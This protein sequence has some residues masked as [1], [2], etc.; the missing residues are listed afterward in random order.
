MTVF[1]KLDPDIITFHILPN[2]D[3]KT[4]I[5]LSSVSSQFHDL[6]SKINNN[7]DLWRN[8]CISTWPSL[9]T[10]FP[11]KDFPSIISILLGGYRS[12]FLD[13]FPSIHPPLNNP[14]PPTLP[15]V[16]SFFYALDISLHGEQQPFYSLHTFEST[17]THEYTSH[18]LVHPL[19]FRFGL[20]HP[21]AKRN[22]IIK[23]KKEGCEEYLKQK[24]TFS[25]VAISRIGIKR[26]GSLFSGCKAVS[27]QPDNLGVMVVFETVLPVPAGLSVSYTEMVKCRIEV[28]CSWKGDEEDKFFVNFIYLTMKD[29][30]GKPLL[31]RH[32]AAVVLNAIHNGE[33]RGRST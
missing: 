17:K 2:L 5:I 26:A 6:I 10:N 12:L 15:P 14:L 27:A 19:I 16:V 30:N 24:M 31:E 3:G 20:Y 13:A 9:L 8:I 11:I 7:S 29:M 4:L 18:P 28:T 32:G 1:S 23:V 21:K 25:C 33:R 22:Y